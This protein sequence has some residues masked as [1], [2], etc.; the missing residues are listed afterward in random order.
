MAQEAHAGEAA[1]QLV[2]GPMLLLGGLAMGAAVSALAH[3]S[4]LEASL[5]LMARATDNLLHGPTAGEDPGERLI[6]QTVER[7][8][9]RVERL[10][11]CQA[12]DVRPGQLKVT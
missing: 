5:S 12:R 6:K 9:E 7:L 10:S 11:L 2:L 3:G 8:A 1:R 4:R